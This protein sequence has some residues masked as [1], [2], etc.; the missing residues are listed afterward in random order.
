MTVKNSS[1]T[2]EFFNKAQML[3]NLNVRGE[4]L[5]NKPV[6]ALQFNT[7]IPE[8]VK[9][10]FTYTSNIDLGIVSPYDFRNFPQNIVLNVK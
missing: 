6:E 1:K 2:S 9:G 8:F 3:Y 4:L 7:S 10:Y 5:N